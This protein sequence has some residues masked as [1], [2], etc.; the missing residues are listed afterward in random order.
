MSFKPPYPNILDFHLPSDFIC[1]EYFE[2][3]VLSKGY[4]TMDQKPYPA[5]L[6]NE[7]ESPLCLLTLTHESHFSTLLLLQTS[8]AQRDFLRQHYEEKGQKPIFFLQDE[9]ALCRFC[10]E[11]PRNSLC[12]VYRASFHATNQMIAVMDNEL[13]VQYVNHALLQYLGKTPS[14]L[15]GLPYWELDIWRH[16]VELQNKVMFSLEQIYMGEKVRFETTHQGADGNLR[17]VDFILN[18]IFDEKGEV[19]LIIAMGYD[20]TDSKLTESALKRTEKELKLFFDYSL[21][22]YF[23]NRLS[24]KI[25]LDPRHLEKTL[26]YI[27]HHEKNSIYNQALLQILAVDGAYFQTHSILDILSIPEEEKKKRWHEM[28]AQGHVQFQAEIKKAENLKILDCT[29]APIIENENEYIGS[30]G[31]INDITERVILERKMVHLAT[32]DPLTDA[33]NRRNYLSLATE[34]INRLWALDIHPVILMIDIDNFKRVNDTYGHDIGDKVLIQMTQLCEQI[35]EGEGIFGR[36]GGEEFSALLFHEG[37]KA[38]RLAETLRKEIADI[39][40]KTPLGDLRFTVS[41]GCASILPEMPLEKG[42]KFADEALYNAKETG[43]NKVVFFKD[44]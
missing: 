22:G 27:R 10:T 42:L 9:K 34:Q 28:I 38:A 29:L 24:E 26:D 5:W 25:Y 2:A 4:I 8:Y 43:K 30:F 18:A 6:G 33:N 40:V 12:H 13:T 16:S 15:S 36:M 32:K 1:E 11:P 44:K 7:K 37:K 31:I 17:D 14:A 39:Q 35:L 41:I 20:V 23:I 21:N 19:D 3:Q